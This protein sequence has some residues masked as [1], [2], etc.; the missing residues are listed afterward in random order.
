MTD[1]WLLYNWLSWADTFL[2]SWREKKNMFLFTFPHKMI[3]AQGQSVKRGENRSETVLRLTP[4]ADSRDLLK[5][6]IKGLCRMQD[7]T[8]F[9]MEV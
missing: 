9:T 4:F 1:W 3:L 5:Y 2:A 7:G 6:I 8:E